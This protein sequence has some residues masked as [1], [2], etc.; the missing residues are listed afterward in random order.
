MRLAKAGSKKVL[1]G[2]EERQQEK[3]MEK[4]ASK[5]DTGVQLPT[6]ISS[7]KLLIN[8]YLLLQSVLVPQ[9]FRTS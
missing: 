9:T 5:N 7:S 1:P 3:L 4:K 2:K 6:D 8:L